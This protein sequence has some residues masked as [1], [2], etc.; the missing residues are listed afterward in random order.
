LRVKKSS[1]ITTTISTIPTISTTARAL[2]GSLLALA[3]A[4]SWPAHAANDPKAARLYEDALQR[5]EKQDINGA[6]VQL[7]NALQVDKTMLPVHVLLGRA[8]LANGDVIGAEVAFNEALRL[9]VNRAEVV[10]PLARA[11]LGQ[12]KRQ[13]LFDDPRFTVNGLM[14]GLRAQ[15]LLLQAS[16]HADL[17]RAREA[18]A[19]IEQV[20]AIEPGS[21]DSY[22]AEVPIR[23]R[24]RQFAEAMAAADRAVALAPNLAEAHYLRASVAHAQS[25]LAEALAGYSRALRT[26]PDHLESLLA[27]AGIALD[28]NRLTEAKLDI[29]AARRSQ[30]KEPRAAYLGAVIAEREG[31]GPV[32]RAALAEI[33]GLIDPVPAS[34]LRYRPQLLI[35]GG[36]AH[37]GL[38]QFEKARP[39]FEIVQRDQAGSPVAKLLAQ[40]HLAE[41]N[42]DRAVE[43]LDLYLRSHPRDAQALNLLASAHMAQGR[44]ARAAQILQE[45]LATRDDPQLRTLLG[46]SLASAG[47]LTDALAPLEAAYARDPGQVQAGVALVNLYLRDKRG[48]RAIEVA[49]ALVKRQPAQPGL[50]N[51]LGQAR[52]QAGDLARARTAF[53]EAARLDPA[54][55]AP[56][57]NLARLD[58][59]GN[60]LD[61][62]TTRL[63]ALLQA[64]DKNVEVLTELGRLAERRGQTEEATRYFTKAADHSAASDLQPSLALLD[65]HLRGGRIEG[66][67]EAVKR[68]DAK[69]PED[70]QVLMAGARVALAAKNMEL[71]RSILVKASRQASFDA[72]DQTGI[73]LL[74]LAAGDARA[75]AYS[76]DK[77]L[78]GDP[79]HLPAQALM[80]DA[81]L[82]LGD[83]AAAEARAQEVARAQP[84]LAVGHALLG[85]VA[86]AR[87]NA[88][89]A[90]DAY[91]RAH[92]LEPTS[93]SLL[94]LVRVTSLRDRQGALA[95]AEQWLRTRPQD[96]QVRRVLADG[97]AS[98]G[99]MPAARRAYE[100]LL[101]QAPNDAE[102]LNNYAHVLL[103]LKDVAGAQ[104][105]ASLALAARPNA[106]HVL[107]TAGWM[108]Y[109]AGQPDRALQLLRDARLRDPANAETRYYLASVLAS[110]GR[111]AEARDE[112]Q[113]AL[114]AGSSFASA[115]EAQA[116]L[117]TLR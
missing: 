47:K 43:V 62:A 52:M 29:S 33:T 56:R 117:D 73:A 95:L 98:R 87:G 89:A 27:R 100:Q 13:P 63:A 106:P 67:Q 84:Q 17:G 51:L 20:R 58:M 3:L 45:A 64:D 57:V 25:N 34:F 59:R 10:V 2:R 79:A 90:L 115:R 19:A 68:L 91:R 78:K 48:K 99:D 111:A 4:V 53:D 93:Q 30:P 40:I 16:A 36:L 76:L 69:G 7:R 72:P 103:R 50:H 14:P 55:V 21:A 107:G 82:Q 75:A 12:G 80:V 22:L 102:A 104:R 44:H 92:Q 18:L 71:A 24:A 70:Q 54:F 85:D 60:Q 9:G 108:A 26:Q 28:Q 23:V 6:I 74:Q 42:G 35:L 101:K 105:A 77:A 32:A 31:N 112:L 114:R 15:L 8:M 81:Q 96:L 97:Y 94:R 11:L 49:E 83:L 110:T 1:A 65:H 37:H 109:Q 66:A 39:Y 41:K 86:S 88:A 38:G 61:S 5:F 46:L 116:L 113:A